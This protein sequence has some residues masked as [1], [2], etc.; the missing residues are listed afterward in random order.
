MKVLGYL[1]DDKLKILDRVVKGNRRR[2]RPQK[3][4]TYTVCK[5]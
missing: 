1:A 5:C 4:W 2:D 3:C